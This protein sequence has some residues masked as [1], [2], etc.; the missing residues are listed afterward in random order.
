MAL[1]LRELLLP[2][3]TVFVYSKAQEHLV[4][5]D[6][7]EA[8][9]SVFRDQ[10][11]LVVLLFGAPWGDTPW[12]R[13]EEGAIQEL[14]FEDGWEHLLFVRLRNA[15]PTPKWVPKP[16]L[17]LDMSHFGLQELVGAIKL[18]L[19]ELGTEAR[20]VSPA[21]RAAAQERRRQFEEETVELLR[22]KRGTYEE[23]FDALAQA[24]RSE[25]ASITTQTG[26]RVEVGHPLIKASQTAI[27]VAAQGQSVCITSMRRYVNSVDDTYLQVEEFD[28][29]LTID[30]I[31]K[32]FLTM[33]APPSR[34]TQR[35]DLRRLPELGWCWEIDGTPLA[36]QA[37]AERIIHLLLDRIEETQM[38]RGRR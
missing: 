23:A 5:R 38:P 24:L 10:A 35:A 21:D 31:A 3:Y 36:P 26:W 27:A 22:N 13:V 20:H 16:H 18:R 7:I 32:H 11:T 17:Y 14:A 25:A 2:S 4:G 28:G 29:P 9:R 8:C 30:E 1:Q 12:T 34:R 15:D 37:A 19:A 6:G 33:K